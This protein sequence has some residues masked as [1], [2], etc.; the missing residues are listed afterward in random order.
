MSGAIETTCSP[1]HFEASS[2]PTTR[3]RLKQRQGPYTASP[4]PT[5]RT[6][7]RLLLRVLLR[8]GLDVYLPERGPRPTISATPRQARM[9]LEAAGRQGR[10][11]KV[12]DP[13]AA[14]MR[15]RPLSAVRHRWLVPGRGP[16]QQFG[17]AGV[18][19]MQEIPF[20]SCS[21]CLG[22]ED[23]EKRTSIVMKRRKSGYSSGS[24]GSTIGLS[25]FS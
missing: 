25:S 2:K 21:I 6:S 13:R 5:G 18:S 9:R 3:T 12:F 17:A 10:Q 15:N 20:I 16:H 8:R 4:P 19:P 1:R 22:Q 7:R 23:G 14:N 11:N 24:S